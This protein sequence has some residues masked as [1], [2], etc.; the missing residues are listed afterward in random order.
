MR[1]LWYQM[2]TKLSIGIDANHTI[3]KLFR[4]KTVKVYIVPRGH[5]PRKG[6][7]GCA[8]L[9]TPFSRLS[10]ISQGSHFKPKS[11]KFSSQD[12]ILRKM[13][14]SAFT[15][16][17][18]AINLSSPAPKF[19]NFSS[20]NPSVRGNNKFISPTLQKSGSHTRYLKK[21]KKK[22]KKKN[23]VPPAG[24]VQNKVAV[25]CVCWEKSYS[26]RA[27][28][29][30][31][32]ERWTFQCCDRQIMAEIHCNVTL[33]VFSVSCRIL[34]PKKGGEEELKNLLAF[35]CVWDV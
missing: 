17:I 12:S 25:S 19:D 4:V 15:T 28:M 13:E 16:S 33:N 18:F 1:L 21:K 31:S 10:R 3:E 14:I 9:K 22:K 7:W 35:L 27:T 20:Q 5:L 29:V 23:W 2:K 34:F 26:S 6:L 24:I 11:L 30:S 8:A 32:I